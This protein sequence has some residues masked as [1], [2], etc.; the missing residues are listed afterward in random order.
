VAHIQDFPPSKSISQLRRLLEMLSFY[1]QF[2][3]QAAATQAALHKILSGR[4]MK[5]CHPIAWTPELQRPLKNSRQVCR[6]TGLPRPSRTHLHSSQTPA[7]LSWV[8]QQH[9]DNAWQPLAFFS[10]LNSM[11]QKCSTYDREPLAA[12]EAVKH[13][14]PCWKRAT[15][16]SSRPNIE[17]ALP[18]VLLGIHTSSKADLQASVAE[19]VYGE[20]LRIPGKVLTPT[21]RP[22]EPVHL[23]TQ[24]HRHMA[25]LRAVP[26]TRHAS[27]G[28]FVHKDLLN[29]TLL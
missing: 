16:S 18:L 11:Q 23:I 8:S 2:L 25:C 17:Q 28:T 27:P 9:V 7:L 19:L 15:S 12:Y 14:S 1:T 21:A 6:S 5:G 24:L 20:P 22:M 4:R 13:F 10:K 29:C 26:A 3:P